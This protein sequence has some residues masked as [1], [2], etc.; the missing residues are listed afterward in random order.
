VSPTDGLLALLLVPFALNGWRQGLCREGFD[1]V[2]IIGGLI[3]AAA[4]APSIAVVLVAQSVPK[5]AA[6]PIALVGI[7]IL[8]M[9]IARVVGAVVAQGIRA[10]RLGGIDR[11]AGGVFGALKGAACIGLILTLLDRLAP[12][13]SVQIAI[14][15]SLLGPQLMRVAIRALEVG[16]ELTSVAGGA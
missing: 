14:Q 1:L 11:G 6:F 13:P 2:G 15:G 3:V 10:V 4:A 7:L 9:L 12:T 8:A 16:R 5:L